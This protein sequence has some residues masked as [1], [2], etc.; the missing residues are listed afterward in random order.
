[1]ISLAVAL[2]VALLVTAMCYGAVEAVRRLA[3]RRGMLDVPD[4]RRSHRVPTPRGGGV[5]IVVAT[6]LA[7]LVVASTSAVRL[8]PAVVAWLAGGAA[9]A[10]AGWTD[11]ARSLSSRV[12]LVVQVGAAALVLAGTGCWRELA[13]PLA[14]QVPLS[15]AGCPL[16]LLWIVGMTN[17]YNFMD[18][19]DGIAAGQAIV[20]GLAWAIIGRLAQAPDVAAIGG[21]IALSSTAFLLHNRPPA[22][23][24]MG[25]VGSGFLGFTFAALP[26][27][28]AVTAAGNLDRPRL[29]VTGAALVWPFLFDAAFTFS[30]RLA[31]GENVFEPHRRHL[32]QR[33]VIAGASHAGVASLFTGW[34]LVSSALG[35]LWLRGWAA[36][37]PFL[38]GWAL[39][40][41]AAVVAG[42][43]AR[44]RRP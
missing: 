12:R 9:V 26:L 42:V 13:L 28:L 44:E 29:P 8:G 10:L 37:G 43:R 30:A 6:L 11:D 21:A 7:P 39:L 31:R 25:D 1:V 34:A 17:A 2:A 22:R 14:G 20:A 35:I 18:G 23:I 24:F 15:W 32:Y 27:I 16:A 36:A 4:P 19:I 41:A 3:I 38:L 40:S 33:L 5:V